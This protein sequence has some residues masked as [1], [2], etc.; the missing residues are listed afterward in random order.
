M[1]KSKTQ[2][3][4]LIDHLQNKKFREKVEE[5]AIRVMSAAEGWF[6][7]DNA[8]DDEAFDWLVGDWP[9]SIE[10][11]I[12]CQCEG[13]SEYI[14]GEIVEK[15]QPP[16][17][18]TVDELNDAFEVYL[19][20][21]D[22]RIYSEFDILYEYFLDYVRHRLLSDR[23]S[24]PIELCNLVG[25]PDKEEE[26]YLNV[27][28]NLKQKLE[29]SLISGNQPEPTDASD[30]DDEVN[31]ID[32]DSKKCRLLEVNDIVLYVDGIESKKIH[33]G[34]SLQYAPRKSHKLLA[35][36]R[37]KM[38][39]VAFSNFTD[40]LCK[41]TR[42]IF[43]SVLLIQERPESYPPTTIRYE[44]LLKYLP[45]ITGCLEV[46]IKSDYKRGDSLNRRFSNALKLLTASDNQEEK[47][48]QVSLSVAA[49]DALLGK[50]EQ[51]MAK[52]LADR[53]MALLEPDP[54]LR[55]K[56]YDFMKNLYGKRSKTLHGS[57]IEDSGYVEQTR[58]LAACCLYSLWVGNGFKRR[59]DEG[60]TY[61]P[62]SLFE[63]LDNSAKS[64]SRLDYFP[65][66][67]AARTLWGEEL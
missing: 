15:L 62:D 9:N 31:E 6:N 41:A 56:A 19:K 60:K 16:A 64:C 30:H 55:P 25:V 57:R 20:A 7:G 44:E 2:T 11:S 4:I 34:I 39:P 66:I 33:R 58:I 23:H 65:E 10:L 21:H 47:A 53:V 24:P 14:F 61:S 5:W 28:G 59:M 3:E 35:S 54:S 43:Y 42:S 52:S 50:Q 51:E 46:W 1:S 27:I 45:F 36:V 13:D 48:V 37:G 29:Q 40:K 18:V 26:L 32:M 63:E 12:D 49:I 22:E 38:S 8:D 17:I 67:P